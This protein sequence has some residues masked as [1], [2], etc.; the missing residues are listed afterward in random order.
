MSKMKKNYYCQ[1]CGASYNK[2]VGRCESCGEWNQIVEETQHVGSLLKK[3]KVDVAAFFN[4]L[5]GEQNQTQKGYE[6]LVTGMDEFDRV[7]GG[8]IVPGSVILVG[9]DPGIGKSTLLLQIAAHLSKQHPSVYVSGEEALDQ[10][11]MRARRLG[12]QDSPLSLAASTNLDETI[13]ALEKFQGL[14]LAIIDSIQTMSLSAVDSPAGSVSQVRSCAME[15]TR[16]AKKKGFSVILV[17]HVTKE[18]TLAGPRVLEHMVDTVLY[19]EGER[20]YDYRLLRGVKNRF[21]A[22]DEIGVFSM[23]EKGLEEIK[24]PS[25]LFLS[26]SDEPI[27]GCTVFPAMEGTRPLFVDI[28]VLVAPS[29]FPSLKRTSVGWDNN[30]LAMVLAVLEARCGYSFGNKDVYVNISGGLKIVEPAVDLAICTALISAYLNKPVPPKNTFCGE[31]SLTGEVR[32]INRLEPRLKEAQK[33]GFTRVVCP[34]QNVLG[35]NHQTFQI[36]HLTEI[37]KILG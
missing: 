35:G 25:S 12:V 27:P 14:K 4:S 9:G 17:G 32:S 33:L 3:P 30:R 23:T 24:N 31:I 29:Y 13:G 22:T 26:H 7:C 20:N 6:R 34:K 5:E 8:G 21:G 37:G 1:S 36:S 16:A 10:I 18:G 28:Q 15:L 11:R 19:F 2:W